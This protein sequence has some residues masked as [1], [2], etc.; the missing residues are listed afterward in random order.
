M[1]IYTL[2]V[3]G[4]RG[5]KEPS[6][7][8]DDNEIKTN[9]SKFAELIECINMGDDDVIVLQEIPHKIYDK[10]QQRWAWKEND[11]YSEFCKLF[12]Q[13]EYKI[14]WP[15]HLIDSN[16]C[17][18]ALCKTT[19]EWESIAKEKVYYSPE[20]DYGNKL[21]ELQ[22]GEKFTLLGIHMAPEN[23]MWDLLLNA[24]RKCKHTFIVGDLNAYECR[25]EMMNMPQCLKNFGFKPQISSNIIT[26]FKHISSIDNIYV[27]IGYKF[28]SG[29][30]I[31]VEK[32][33]SF[34][35]D[36]ALCNIE[37]SPR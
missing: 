36:H 10:S 34:V 7:S 17:T 35:T 18:V 3:N 19:S 25:G 20:Y 1:K 31:K 21:V 26:N 2:N 15:K 23:E 16:Q 24:E 22:Y 9:L 13:L 32:L 27:D 33:Y 28:N 37:F 30:S 6:D 29:I 4:F 8:V 12:N 5:S 14:I 11:F